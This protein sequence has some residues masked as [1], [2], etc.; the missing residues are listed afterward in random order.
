[1]FFF[2]SEFHDEGGTPKESSQPGPVQ[3]GVASDPSQLEEVLLDLGPSGNAQ[4]QTSL[5][6][7][8]MS[9]F[10]YGG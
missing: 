2:E 4:E 8:S 9:N 5:T 6:G 10:D 3:G 7:R 1:M